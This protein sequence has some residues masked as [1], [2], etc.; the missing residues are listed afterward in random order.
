MFIG[1]VAQGTEEENKIK[2]DILNLIMSILHYPVVV[3]SHFQWIVFF[4]NEGLFT[5]LF[6]IQFDKCY[7]PEPDYVK[8]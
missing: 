7:K 8:S 2:S 3:N 6:L 1:Y 4:N 5:A